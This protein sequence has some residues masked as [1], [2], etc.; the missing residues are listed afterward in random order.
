MDTPNLPLAAAVGVRMSF[1]GVEVLKGV[2][3]ELRAGEVHGITGENGAGKSTLGKIIAGVHR[4]TGGHVELAGNQVELK[5]PGEAAA[6]G[7][8]LIHQEPLTFPHLSVAE[9]IFIGRQPRTKTGAVDWRLMNQQAGDLLTSLATHI[10][11]S[12]RVEGL[13]IAGQQMVELAAAL[14]QKA[15]VLILDETT[16]SLTPKEVAELFGIVRRLR[17]QGCA[18]AFVSH[19][20]EEVFE[21][22][23][24]VTVLRDGAKVGEVLPST[25]SIADVVRLMI[26]RDTQPVARI[27]ATTTKPAILEVERLTS[28]GRFRDISFS[29]RPG[30]TV[31]LAGLVGSGRTEIV[32]AIFGVRSVDAGRIRIGGHEVTICS[33][34]HALQH[35]LAFVPEDRQHHGLLMRMSIADNSTLSILSRLSR[36]WT[37]A[38]R[39]TQAAAPYTE[40]LRLAFR[41]LSQPVSEL[42][43]GNQQK[44]V[45]TK[46]LLTKPKVLIIDEPTRG[47][48][49]GAK[50]EV[51]RL[52]AELASE[53][54]AIL[55][56]SSD[57]S[58]VLEMADR[59]IVM[60][61]GTIAA[62]LDGRHADSEAVMFAATGQRT[63]VS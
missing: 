31:A 16:A 53:G 28:A 59:V 51:H 20:L 13:S 1:G 21:I 50:A 7:M 38:T 25:S 14:S 9:N 57:L 61:E 24:R 3:L 37:S 62:E 15:K 33:P 17:E 47:V 45:L 8:A 58:E 43:G 54:L 34:R 48:G 52:L 40:R 4:P 35:G 63:H 44:V 22:C 39:E 49:I 60:R 18:I 56:V 29:V 42:S 46:W 36:I 5:S 27:P 23:G 41:N 55:M 2:D 6:A 19:R 32:E 30:E 12:H 26:G 11:A 10:R